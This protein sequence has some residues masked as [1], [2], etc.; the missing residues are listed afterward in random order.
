VSR[1]FKLFVVIAMVLLVPVRAFAAVTLGG[2]ASNEP[3]AAAHVHEHDGH[4]STHQHEPVPKPQ[5]HGNHQCN[6][7]A[8]HCASASLAVQ[9]LASQ[10][11]ARPGGERF[12]FGEPFIAGFIPEHLDPPPLAV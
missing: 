4:G 12:S 6:A 3:Q 5:S 10:P 9:A 11:P 8:E 7:C 1:T 2:C